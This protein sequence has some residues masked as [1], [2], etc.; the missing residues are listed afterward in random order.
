M[1]HLGTDEQ[2]EHLTFTL[3][4]TQQSGVFLGSFFLVVLKK[5]GSHQVF[6]LGLLSAGQFRIFLLH[7]FMLAPTLPF[8]LTVV[9][10]FRCCVESVLVCMCM[11]PAL[12][13]KY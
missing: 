2:F 3:M 12:V 11:Y 13:F 7:Y 5:I 1:D 9:I 10:F 8:M 4:H 6:S